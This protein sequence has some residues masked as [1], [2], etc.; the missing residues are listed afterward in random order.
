MYALENKHSSSQQ[1][2]LQVKCHALKLQQVT[3]KD[4]QL[5]EYTK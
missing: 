3:S 1:Q 5:D 2:T 4:F